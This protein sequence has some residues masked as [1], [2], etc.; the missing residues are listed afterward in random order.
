MLPVAPPTST[1]VFKASSGQIDDD[2]VA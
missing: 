2:V 1:I